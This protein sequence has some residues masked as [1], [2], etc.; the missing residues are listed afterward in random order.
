MP[1]ADQHHLVTGATGFVGGALV[2][3]LLES[4]S[5]PITC[6]VRPTTGVTAQQRLHR[7]LRATALSYDAEHL[8]DAI[9]TRCTAIPGDITRPDCGTNV[10]TL[11]RFDQVWHSAASLEYEDERAQQIHLHNVTGTRRVLDIARRRD[12]A[13]FNYVS[14]AYVCGNRTGPIPVTVTDTP[15]TMNN[16]YE[17]SKATAEQAVLHSG[18]PQVRI[19]RPSIVIG[20]SRTFATASST[21]LY[22]FL[23]Q[24]R[25]LRV[26][27]ARVL[28]DLFAFRSL[29]IRGDATTQLNLVPVDAVARAAVGIAVAGGHDPIYHLTNTAMPS[30]GDAMAIGTRLLSM[31][32]PVFVDDVREFT[33]IDEQ[34]DQRLGFYRSYL[35]GT[36][37]FDTANVEKLIGAETLTHPMDEDTITQYMSW[38]LHRRPAERAA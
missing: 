10:D 3:E 33:S 37:H 14:T 27:V 9:T 24:L 31:R 30:L 4:T 26:E 25:L 36:K 32:Q 18:L 13:V 2:L 38:Y 16:E 21:G 20:H 12:T 34:V 17:R 8:L 7:S 1:T 11:P 22:G 15:T 28:G 35:R 23:R 19:L 5:D 29:R 6:L